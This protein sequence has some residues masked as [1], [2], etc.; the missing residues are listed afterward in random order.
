L[1]AA[2]STPL[3]LELRDHYTLIG[4]DAASVAR[5]HE[6]VVGCKPLRL[7]KV[8]AGSVPEGEYDMLTDRKCKRGVGVM[9]G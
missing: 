6:E 5:F 1:A 4:D 2:L 3:Q 9:T 8:N 7:Q